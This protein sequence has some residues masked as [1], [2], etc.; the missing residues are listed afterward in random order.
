MAVVMNMSGYE[1]EPNEP[2]GVGRGDETMR[3]EW[4]PE[5]ALL[6]VWAPPKDRGSL[7]RELADVDV[8]TFLRKMQSYPR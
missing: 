6:S 5:L 2:E 3:A 1:I 8:D 7:P 4:N